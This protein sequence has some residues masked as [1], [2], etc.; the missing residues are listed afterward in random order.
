MAKFWILAANSGNAKLFSSDSPTSSLVEIET[1]V[2]SVA[3]AK[4][5]DLTS[6]RPGRSFDSHGQGRH[7]MEVRI[8]PKEQNQLNFAKLIAER[9]EQGR[10]EEAFEHIVLVAAPA[11]LGQLRANFDASL[12]KL[13][14]LEIDKDYTSLRPDEL[15]SLLPVRLPNINS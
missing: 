6:D 9:L 4:E 15:R 7:A 3:R 13:V 12:S 5:I 14:C 8:K 1:F 11:F 2:N 10:I